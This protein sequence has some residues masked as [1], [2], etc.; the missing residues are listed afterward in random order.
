MEDF[1]EAAIAFGG[2]RGPRFQDLYQRMPL[3]QLAS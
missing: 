2:K 3:S 1:E